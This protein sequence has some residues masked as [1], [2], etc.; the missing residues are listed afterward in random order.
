[1]KGF[2]EEEKDFVFSPLGYSVVL[3]IMAEGARGETRNQ[4]VAALRLPEDTYAVRQNYKM[5]LESMKDRWS[6]NK[7][8]FK[9]W[10][11]VY[12]NYTVDEKYKTILLENYLTEVKHVEKVSYDLDFDSE[13]SVEEKVGVTEKDVEKETE[14]ASE[15]SRELEVSRVEEDTPSVFDASK[16][17]ATA[18]T[19][20]RILDSDS[21][22]TEL[23]SETKMIIFNGFYFRGNWKTPFTLTK[24]GEKQRFY[25][26][27]S[28]KKQ[29]SMMQTSGNFDIGTVP[30]LDAVALELPYEGNQ[31]SMLVLLPNQRDGLNKLTSDITGF[32]LNRVYKHLVNR[33]VEILLPKY[34]IQTISHPEKLLQKY[35]VS[36]IFTSDADLSGISSDKLK[37][38]ALVQLVNIQI[39]EGSAD[40]NFL[41][42]T[43]AA[44][45]RNN[46]ER[47]VADHPFLFFIRDQTKNL[48]VAAGKVVDPEFK[49]S[50]ELAP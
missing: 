26:S 14:V 47:F 23:D 24:D 19:A 1:M 28:E 8:E 43:L 35:G 30:E 33:P 37:M 20:N 44:A 34:Q 11:Y 29:V 39:D 2:V 40:A 12:K 50:D 9:N 36:D 3:A 13:E 18:L 15:E 6:I 27:E 49:T 42:T 10:F 5:I 21:P 46:A 38:G 17:V 22:G 32:S 16:D 4:L 45:T 48:I 41:T 7:P 25:K 31:Y